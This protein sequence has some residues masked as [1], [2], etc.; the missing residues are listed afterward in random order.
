VRL[1]LGRFVEGQHAGLSHFAAAR[2]REQPAANSASLGV[3][4]VG[5]ERVIESSRD[6]TFTRGPALTSDVVWLKSTWGL[7]GQSQFAFS[8]D[9]RT[10]LPFGGT[11][12]LAW[13]AYRGDRIGL[14]TFNNRTDEGCVDFADFRFSFDGPESAR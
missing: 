12:P 14:F 7:D 2:R 13:G 10:F 1:D 5:R 6:G 9:G 4:Q 3:V 8:T 11:Y